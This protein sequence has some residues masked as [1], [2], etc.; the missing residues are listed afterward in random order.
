MPAEPIDVALLVGLVVLL[1]S[2]SRRL[3]AA[4]LLR[5]DYADARK[6]LEMER[7]LAEVDQRVHLLFETAATGVMLVNEDGGVLLINRR[8]RALL[9]L[10]RRSA[11]GLSF[12]DLLAPQARV[13]FPEL[14]RALRE[15]GPQSLTMPLRRADGAE[16]DIAAELTVFEGPRCEE[17]ISVFLRP[18]G[19]AAADAAGG[20]RPNVVLVVD[21][22]ELIRTLARNMIVRLGY[23][24]LAAAD[25]NEA[26]G[27]FRARHEQLA[28]VIL[29]IFMPGQ[30]GA[31]VARRMRDIDP[32]VPIIF[33]SGFNDALDEETADALQPRLP[34]PFS[35]DELTQV[36]VRYRR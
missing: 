18:A 7:Q 33:C 19:E 34:K 25:G 23:P 36:L 24:A 22:E 15:E 8:A 16:M 4:E 30:D 13:H 31:T 28:A 12:T 26:V 1:T 27:L 20:A 14:R 5:G 35:L 21:D 29:D 10:E 17:M 6:A 9:G 2:W 11:D 32:A 3:R